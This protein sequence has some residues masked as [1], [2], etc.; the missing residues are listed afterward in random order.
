MKHIGLIACAVA[1]VLST[2]FIKNE[3]GG[4]NT[5]LSG[6]SEKAETAKAQAATEVEKATQQAEAVVADAT[7]KAE[8]AVEA[9]TV[10]AE[11]IMAN[12]NLSPE[13]LKEMIGT[14]TPESLMAYAEQYRILLAEKKAQI[15]DLT[16]QYKEMAWYKRYSAKG[17]VVKEQLEAY[18]GQYD[19]L[20]EQFNLYAGKLKEFGVGLSVPGL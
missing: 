1:T 3:D 7:A 5:D 10:K 16:T 20:M 19:S 17:K 12:L 4:L 11:D 13:A 18:K 2:G 14:M 9:I 6:L 8:A 15:S